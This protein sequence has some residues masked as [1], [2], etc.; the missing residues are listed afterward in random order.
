[1]KSSIKVTTL[2][3]LIAGPLL[4]SAALEGVGELITSI[5]GL[6]K[7]ALPIAVAAALLFFFWGVANFI[8]KAGDPKAR[9]EGRNRMLWGI[10]ALF[11]MISVWGI[12][13]FIQENLNIYGE[14]SI[15]NQDG[16]SIINPPTPV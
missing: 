2:S 1:M 8:L 11:V 10:I 7:L 9:E 16:D 15:E 13:G 14:D 12:V 4:V 3:I 6:I 5:G